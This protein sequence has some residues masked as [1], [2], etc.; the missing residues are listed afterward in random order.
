MGPTLMENPEFT[1][2]QIIDKSIVEFKTCDGEIMSDD[3]KEK[4]PQ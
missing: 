3:Q 1:I 4:E 2:L